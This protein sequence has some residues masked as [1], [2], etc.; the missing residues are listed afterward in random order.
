MVV[1]ILV[2]AVV[3]GLAF[4]ASIAGAQKDRAQ[5][6][7]TLSAKVFRPAQADKAGDNLQV[8]RGGTDRAA[9]AA[10]RPMAEGAR[11]GEAL[12]GTKQ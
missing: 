7:E 3:F 1:K 10:G 11:L 9:T 2:G 5:F 4:M 6:G 8:H 12:K